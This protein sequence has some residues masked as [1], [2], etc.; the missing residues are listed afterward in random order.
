MIKKKENFA[1]FDKLYRCIFHKVPIAIA[2]FF[3]WNLINFFTLVDFLY[4]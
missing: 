1:L 2:F 4:Y 3:K